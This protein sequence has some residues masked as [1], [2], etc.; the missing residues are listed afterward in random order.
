MDGTT[1]AKDAYIYDTFTIS[2]DAAINNF[3]IAT[4]ATLTLAATKGLTV[5]G[6]LTNNGTL[7]ANPGSSLIVSGT[8]TGNVTYSRT[9]TFNADNLKGWHLV[10]SP[11]VGET[12]DDSWITTNSIA[13]G[14]GNNRGIATY[15]NTVA[16]GNWSYFQAGGDTT[17]NSGAGYSV[18]RGTSAG[19]VSFTGTLLTESITDKAIT[20]STQPY[21]LL[22]NPYPSYMNSATFLTDNSAFLSSETIWVWDSSAN[23]G[24]G[25]YVTKTTIDGYQ[26]APGQGFFVSANGNNNVTFNE[27]NQSHQ[28][29]DTFSK[30]ENTRPEIKLFINDGTQEMY[31]K[32]YYIES[33]TP[34][35]DNGYDGETFNGLPNSFEVFT[36]LISDNQGRNFATQSLPNTNYDDMV[37]PVGVKTAAN[38]EVTFT[39][40]AKNLP[41]GINIYLEDRQENTFTRLDEEN[42]NFKITFTEAVNNTGRFYL[43]TSSRSLSTADVFFDSVSIY[44]TDNSTLRITGLQNQDVSISLFNIL[45]KKVMVTTFKA[46]GLKDITLPKLATGIYVVQLTTENGNL[47]K[48]VIIE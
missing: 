1:A 24:T 44:K 18:K 19:T 46:N 30:S 33:T 47:N 37:I 14:T 3:G 16:S 15:N 11:V 38:K 23:S 40:D 35:F 25:A 17:F 20:N 10:S 45:G 32:I 6:N 8:S 27:S 22:G 26:I 28:G 48:K 7:T 41:G 31:T 9:L 39:V 34:G 12:Y 4:G 43:H 2:D 42:S 21:N 5:N 29:T 13:P 36:H